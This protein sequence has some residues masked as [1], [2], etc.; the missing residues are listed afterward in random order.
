MPTYSLTLRR[1]IVRKLTIQE[2][3][4]NFL[5]V[6]ENAS[7][8]QG[9]TGPNGQAGPQGP[10]GPSGTITQYGFTASENITIGKGVSLL[11]DGTVTPTK[12]EYVS[13]GF[14]SSNVCKTLQISTNR[15][16][17]LY[18]K[19]DNSLYAR[20]GVN[21]GQEINFGNEFLVFSGVV[22]QNRLIDLCLVD[23]DK[24]CIAFVENNSPYNSFQN[25]IRLI[26]ASVSGNSISFGSSLFFL[27]W[28]GGDL[29]LVS[30]ST[31][32]AILTFSTSMWAALKKWNISGN[33]ITEA[34]IFT[35]IF[36]SSFNIGQVKPI[37][38]GSNRVAI[39]WNNPNDSQSSIRI[40]DAGSNTFGT[41]LTFE[42]PLPGFQTY[43]GYNDALLIDTDRILVNKSDDNTI[44][45]YIF[46]VTGL[47]VVLDD[48]LET[49]TNSFYQTVDYDGS[50]NIFSNSI[51]LDTNKIAIVL[52]TYN[53]LTPVTISLIDFSSG[54]QKYDE[55][56]VGLNFSTNLISK[57]DTNRLNYIFY[58]D[59]KIE[60][61]SGEIISN[62][63]TNTSLNISFSNY[64][65]FSQ[66]S[67][68]VGEIVYVKFPGALDENQTGLSIGSYYHIDPAG[69]L[70]QGNPSSYSSSSDSIF[71]GKAV[72]SNSL[73]LIQYT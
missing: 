58:K 43:S 67:A 14:D 23:T 46:Q 52:S 69:D 49:N 53:F 21:T 25:R 35:L 27:N 45:H 7:G 42:S 16:F 9:P 36:S 40:F 18:V 22:P 68:S 30:P 61:I 3:D 10:T 65:G 1:D 55:V 33:S 24:I 6:L 62:K 5:Y 2:L 50:N 71:V 28:S 59:D 20:I 47:N 29:N 8:T 60:S 51:L 13:Y 11:P 73:L 70:V 15:S 38:I 54:Y 37:S 44:R 17:Y 12:N 56:T 39:I 19:S 4:D 48:I 72:S 66:N 31:N 64:L 57:V 41:Q 26:V 34:D 32:S 63:F